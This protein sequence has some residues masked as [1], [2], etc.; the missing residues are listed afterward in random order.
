M[1]RISARHYAVEEVN[2]AVYALDNVHRGAYAHK[3]TRLV[4][5]RERFDRL[6]NV[7]H[8]LCRLAD[9][10]TADCVAVKVKFCN[11]LHVFDSDVII[12]A[13]LIDSEQHLTF[14][15]CSVKSVKA[16]KL[17]FAAF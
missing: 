16:R 15:Y 5:G 2:S 12:C 8:N 6:D 17:G 14:V 1:A 3:V 4:C 10:K 13:A 11:L 9:R 7:I